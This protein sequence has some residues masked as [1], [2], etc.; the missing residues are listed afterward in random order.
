MT[1]QS[2]AGSIDSTDS[3]GLGSQNTTTQNV[4]PTTPLIPKTTNQ[5][6]QTPLLDRNLSIHAPD[7]QPIP[8]EMQ[9][10]MKA[11]NDI[12]NQCSVLPEL[13]GKTQ[14]KFE[15]IFQPR[16]GSDPIS[17]KDFPKHP[18]VQNKYTAIM[19]QIYQHQENISYGLLSALSSQQKQIAQ[20]VMQ[21]SPGSMQPNIIESIMH[22]VIQ[23]M[24][25]SLNDLLALQ[26]TPTPQQW[27]NPIMGSQDNRGVMP[28]TMPP[29]MLQPF[30]QQPI[31]QQY[32]FHM[33][34]S[35]PQA[36]QSVPPLFSPMANFMAQKSAPQVGLSCL[37][38]QFVTSDPM[39]LLT[40]P[41]PSMLYGMHPQMVIAPQDSNSDD[42]KGDLRQGEA[43]IDEIGHTPEPSDISTK[44]GK[45]GQKEMSTFISVEAYDDNEVSLQLDKIHDRLGHVLKNRVDGDFNKNI[46]EISDDLKKL[47][48]AE[49]DILDY[50]DKRL[51]ILQDI[52]KQLLKGEEN[53]TKLN[54]SKGY[55]YVLQA[56]LAAT[57]KTSLEIKAENE[58]IK[59]GH[60]GSIILAQDILVALQSDDADTQKAG[61]TGVIKKT[62]T[63]K[64]KSTTPSEHTKHLDNI[65]EIATILQKKIHDVSFSSKMNN[66]Y[67]KRI[68]GLTD[69]LGSERQNNKLK[70]EAITNTQK[71]QNI[72]TDKTTSLL[73]LI[74][75]SANNESDLGALKHQLPSIE[76]NL[77]D[78]IKNLQPDNYDASLSEINNIISA[79]SNLIDTLIISVKERNRIETTIDILRTREK[80]EGDSEP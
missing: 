10:S 64:E 60:A 25:V 50:N 49:H 65:L 51:S 43:E 72:I 6:P 7:V 39:G 17:L 33:L 29:T 11:I 15:I 75:E 3:T 78:K 31:P 45:L 54:V 27:H 68:S 13:L 62:N 67:K 46:S 32:G 24:P 80:Q 40:Q 77:R 35:G 57:E 37:L 59:N 38:P 12:G 47:K 79:Y 53:I 56:K 20:L 34:P 58:S 1:P 19:N 22:P 21:M 76:D 5:T 4:Q 63:E 48:E 69:E 66:D 41:T 16:N 9:S 42:D 36:G 2:A 71:I 28:Q 74:T 30:M 8:K 70:Q 44:K 14:G 55:L 18:A 73:K 26:G 23:P 52:I 61:L